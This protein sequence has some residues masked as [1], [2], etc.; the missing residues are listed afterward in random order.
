MSKSIF[1]TH[2]EEVKDKVEQVEVQQEKKLSLGGQHKPHKGHKVWEYN[3]ATNEI[4]EAEMEVLPAI[5]KGAVKRH[6]NGFPCDIP[7]GVRQKL[8]VKENCRY[9]SALNIKNA[10]KKFGIDAKIVKLKN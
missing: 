3:M 10:L 7:A 1:Y 2:L 6:L 4:Q 5:F 9:E 8:I